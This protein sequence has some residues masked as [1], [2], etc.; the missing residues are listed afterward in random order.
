MNMRDLIT[1]LET[2]HANPAAAFEIEVEAALAPMG[3]VSAI[4]VWQDP[5]TVEIN[6]ISATPMR[7]GWGSKAMA[8]ITALADR[9]GVTLTLEVDNDGDDSWG[10]YDDEDA[11]PEQSDTP[12][13]DDLMGWYGSYGFDVSTSLSSRIQMVR[14]PGAQS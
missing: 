9:H 10:D 2:T 5:H 8:V 11:E 6:H 14:K 13:N 4:L 7:E 12:S 1:L 3:N